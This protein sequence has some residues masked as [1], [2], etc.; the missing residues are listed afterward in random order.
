MRNH[1]ITRLKTLLTAA[2][3]S[4]YT[5]RREAAK[6]KYRLE[7]L[8]ATEDT[9]DDWLFDTTPAFERETRLLSKDMSALSA[10]LTGL[11]E[12]LDMISGITPFPSRAQTD[13]PCA[14][15]TYD[16]DLFDGEPMPDVP[17]QDTVI[18]GAGDVLFDAD[19]TME[20]AQHAA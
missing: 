6:P 10:S 17:A 20:A 18:G 16:S 9:S 19:Q 1:A 11:R 2:C 3:V 13:R 15:M 14:I 5:K 4:L 8:S 12:T 7:P